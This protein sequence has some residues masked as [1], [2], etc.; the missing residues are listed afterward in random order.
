MKR[1]T[2]IRHAKSSH[3]NPG[4]SDLQRPL[5]DRGRKDAMLMSQLLK[6]ADFTAD[7]LMVSLA[8][9]ARQTF[10]ILFQDL[11]PNLTEVS[12][13]PQMYTF[14]C[15]QLI[16]IIEMVDDVVDHLVLVGHNPGMTLLTNHLTDAAIDNVPTCAIIAISLDIDQWV[17]IKERSGTLDRFDVPKNYRADPSG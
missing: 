9:R 12:Y 11:Q 7:R 3:G 13:D 6:E 5:N 10:E 1:L 4:Q 2:L 8:T 17:Q 16:S 15:G 14:D